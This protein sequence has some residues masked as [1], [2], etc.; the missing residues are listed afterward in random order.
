MNFHSYL[1]LLVDLGLKST[2]VLSLA[3]LVAHLWR[4]VSAANRH[5]VWLAAFGVLV[6]LPGVTL[7][8]RS[9]AEKPVEAVARVVLR[10]PAAGMPVPASSLQEALVATSTSPFMTMPGWRDALVA[11]WL[12][13]VLLLL[14]LRLIGGVRLVWQGRQSER[15]QD[16][17]IVALCGRLAAETGIG[18]RVALRWAKDCHVAMTWGTWWPVVMLPAGARAW[19]D[20]RLEWVLRHELAHVK[21]LDCLTRF[22]GQVVCAVYWPNPLTWLA[23]RR[24]R[25][26]QEQACDDRVLV[27]GVAATTYAMEL[28][29]AVRG[30]NGRRRFGGAVA[31]AEPSTLE[32][33]VLGVLGEGRDR[34]ALRGSTVALAS[35]MA[36]LALAGCS[37]VEVHAA[38]EQ[39]AAVAPSD[40]M[41]PRVVIESKFIEVQTSSP[42]GT[43]LLNS[44][45][46]AGASTV[47]T[48]LL[49]PEQN[50]DLMG[51]T[52]ALTDVDLLSAPKVMV[53]SG[54]AADI[55]IVQEMRYPSRWKKDPAGRGWQATD[56]ATRNVGVEMRVTPT[57][58]PDGNIALNLTITVTAFEGYMELDKPPGD[59]SEINLQ[60]AP[61]TN[62]AGDVSLKVE[63]AESGPTGVAQAKADT[64]AELSTAVT[65][66]A[67]AQPIFAVHAVTTNVEVRSGQTL[68]LKGGGI[69]QV[70]STSTQGQPLE[71]SIEI[72]PKTL[73]YFVTASVEPSAKKAPTVTR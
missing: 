16:E 40:S 6:L 5:L 4:D 63:R 21:R 26:A 67:P 56:F 36:L 59:Q 65:L 32:N 35:V 9:A 23:A 72:I 7:L 39:T 61:E 52:N 37:A 54:S 28:V 71:S 46:M 69:D 42:G 51:K 8:S 24:A 12:G 45:G 18:R 29:A 34:C 70:R 66:L 14:T 62:A 1:P 2:L 55:Q 43:V 11:V 19:T 58:K 22:F 41:K 60:V 31:M 48:G 68:V 25:L 17:R 44:L 50:A 64:V 38:R 13:G 73:I 49:A 47:T 33:R 53:L 15:V 10:L 57:V 20:D 27:A 3:W 30:L